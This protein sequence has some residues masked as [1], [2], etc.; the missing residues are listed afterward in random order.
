MTARMQLALMKAGDPRLV[1][2]VLLGVAVL[3]AAVSAGGVDT[4]YACPA[5]GGSGCGAGG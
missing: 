2:V 4:V 3:L 5:Q 1:R